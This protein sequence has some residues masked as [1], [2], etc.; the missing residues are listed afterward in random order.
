MGSFL[1]RLKPISEDDLSNAIDTYQTS[2]KFLRADI[3]RYREQKLKPSIFN[4]LHP[5]GYDLDTVDMKYIVDTNQEGQ[6]CAILKE[7]VDA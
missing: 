1:R 3:E 2:F 7:S 5:W 4:V 6:I